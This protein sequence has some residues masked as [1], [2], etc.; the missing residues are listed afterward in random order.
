MKTSLFLILVSLMLPLATAYGEG[1][2]ISPTIWEFETNRQ[3]TSSSTIWN[4]VVYVGSWDHHLY[5]INAKTGKLK[6]KFETKDRIEASPVISKGVVYIGSTDCYL[7]AIDAKT[8]ELKWKFKTNSYVWASAIVRKGIVYVSPTS[9]DLYAI[10]A[11]TG[12]M[13]WKYDGYEMA[14]GYK[15]RPAVKGGFVY[16]TTDYYLVALD[17]SSGKQKWLSREISYRMCDVIAGSPIVDTNA[18]YVATSSGY[19]TAFDAKTG[20]FK[21][22]VYVEGSIHKTP[23]IKNGVL[24]VSHG[25][26]YLVAINT[27]AV[28]TMYGDCAYGVQQGEII[29]RY[30]TEGEVT[31]LANVE[32]DVVYVG[33][34]TGRLYAIDAKTGK[35]KWNVDTNTKNGYI[36]SSLAIWDGVIYYGSWDGHLYAFDTK[37][38]KRKENP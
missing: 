11:N 22:K 12:K 25:S 2:T 30:E 29:W 32:E 9:N 14:S 3:I 28:T 24:Y 21:W 10:N 7:Y 19:I 20:D 27:A 6:W 37:T 18:V 33:D 31:T 36:S 13:I 17:A 4:G 15:K 35:S 1:Q 16:L 8:G 34:S 5:A 26:N 23:T 38:K